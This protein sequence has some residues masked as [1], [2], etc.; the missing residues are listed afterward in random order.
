VGGGG[1]LGDVGA[2]AVEGREAG[3]KWAD[4]GEAMTEGLGREA[5]SERA[6]MDAIPA[7][8][9]QFHKRPKY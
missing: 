4:V 7:L 9:A 3:T 2:T 6:P 5:G 1:I 8:K